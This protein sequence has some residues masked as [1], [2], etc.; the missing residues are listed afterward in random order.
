M[1]PYDVTLENC[2]QMRKGPLTQQWEWSIVQLRERTTPANAKVIVL[3]N[4]TKKGHLHN[5]YIKI[6]DLLQLCE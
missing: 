5:W 1:I 6:V 2:W 3:R 4:C